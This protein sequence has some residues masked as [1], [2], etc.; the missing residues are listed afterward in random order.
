GY[1][2]EL[3]TEWV[4]TDN[5]NATFNLSYNNTELKDDDLAV[6]VCGQCTVT[7]PTFQVPGAFGPEDRAILDGNS[8]P[9]APE[10]I[11]N[12]T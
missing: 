11:S 12:L 3:D 7:D 5:L 4:L 10:W 1:G 9:H 8:L 2:F 6:A